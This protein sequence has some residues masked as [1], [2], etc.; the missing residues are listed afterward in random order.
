M[1]RVM[2]RVETSDSWD[3]VGRAHHTGTHRPSFRSESQRVTDRQ[4]REMDVLLG[5][6]DG[7]TT[8]VLGHRLGADT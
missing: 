8:K 5:S 3:Q 1:V 7:F 4:G 6:V 2:V